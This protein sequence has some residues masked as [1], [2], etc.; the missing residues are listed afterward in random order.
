MTGPPLVARLVRDDR[1]SHGRN[2][3]VPDRAQR[4]ESLHERLL[5]HVLGIAPAAQ[6]A[7]RP[8]RGSGA[9]DD[10]HLVGVQVAGPG[11]G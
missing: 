2:G 5:H 9:P 6:Q 11:A 3:A 7:R 4:A 10:Q 1:S 8:V